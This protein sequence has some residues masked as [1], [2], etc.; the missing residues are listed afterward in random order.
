MNAIAERTYTFRAAGDLGDRIREASVILDEITDAVGSDL[1]EKIA[2]EMVL[3]M[4]RD[5]ARFHGFR[6]NQSAFVRETVELLVG[7]AKKVASDLRYA[8]VY[9]EAAESRTDDEVEFRRAGRA[10]AAQR[11]RDA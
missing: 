7:A 8:G 4:V 6:G 5:S 11:W 1:A 2:A 3:A 9:A 10:R